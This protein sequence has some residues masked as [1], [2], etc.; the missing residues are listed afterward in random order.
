MATQR[1]CYHC[2]R[3]HPVEE[4]RQVVTAGCVRWRCRR[5]VM[6]ARASREERDSFGRSVAAMNRTAAGK[7]LP[8]CVSELLV[9]LRDDKEW[10]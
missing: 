8:R 9:I 6:A 7:P 10:R 1:F 2:R 4:M 5:S 3:S